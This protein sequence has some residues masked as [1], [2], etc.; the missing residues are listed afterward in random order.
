MKKLITLALVLVLLLSMT[1]CGG[2]LKENGESG[3]T[4][5]AEESVEL[6]TPSTT[7]DPQS[8]YGKLTYTY[9]MFYGNYRLL[10]GDK[11]KEAFGKET[12][13]MDWPQDYAEKLTVLPFQIEAGPHTLSHVVYN[14]EG[15]Q[16]AR[17]HFL[18]ENGNLNMLLG[19][20]T[21]E[22]STLKFTPLDIWEYDSETK[23]ANYTLSP[24]TLEFTFSFNGRSLTLSR[25]G[26]QVTLT[27]GLTVYEDTAYFNTEH[28][29]SQ[30][31]EALDGI[32]TLDLHYNQETGS[33]HIFVESVDGERVYKA[34]ARIQDN[35]LLTLTVPWEAGTK[36][37]QYVY[38]YGHNDGIV[39]TDGT[40][41][42]YY[43][44]DY[45]DRGTQ[46]LSEFV[47]EEQTEQIKDM[48]ENQL[49][50]IVEKKENLLED[51]AAAYET[52]GL[53]VVINETTGE[54]ALDSTILFAVN[55]SQIADAG[56]EFLQQFI[57][58]YTGVV[59]SDKYENFISQILVEGH[60]DTSGSYE[61]NQALSQ[62]RADS[63]KD[64]CLSTD[65]GVDAAYLQ[66]LTDTLQA[67]G[68]SYDRPV[69]DANGEVDMDASRRVSFRFIINLES[70][71]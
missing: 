36:T 17:M 15:Y 10:G 42:Y 55:E 53:N 38:F 6:G 34:I 62:A 57:S 68:Y 16:W 54:I 70:Q 18:N 66:I 26:A 67:I 27:A 64:Y 71:S 25:E 5:K 30:G 2:S 35:G 37:Y 65:C 45:W 7:L 40:N 61:L 51:L 63:V 28:Y 11:A 19:A 9:Q 56:K 21:V 3:Y 22:G 52:A 44:D 69:Y 14:I 31:S 12:P 24:T 13:M 20:Y 33:R 50:T 43:N 41:T 46:E 48:T 8:I 47:T 49:E 58:V 59:F 60:T 39:L 1:A 29:L 4:V 32:D 23:T